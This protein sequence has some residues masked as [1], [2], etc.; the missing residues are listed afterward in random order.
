MQT[1]RIVN[2]CIQQLK[3]LSDLNNDVSS[4]HKIQVRNLYISLAYDGKYRLS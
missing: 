4:I 2:L 3:E 1:K